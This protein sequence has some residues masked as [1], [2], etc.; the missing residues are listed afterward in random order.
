M[1]SPTWLCFG[2]LVGMFQ[3]IILFLVFLY[4]LCTLLLSGALIYMHDY[5]FVILLNTFK[6]ELASLHCLQV[7]DLKRSGLRKMS[8]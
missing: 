4:R 6:D 2:P 7:A 8:K 1:E 5:S 3:I